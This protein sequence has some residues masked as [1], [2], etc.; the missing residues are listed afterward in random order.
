M[1]FDLF[2]EFHSPPGVTEAAPPGLS[3]CLNSP[4]S[5]ARPPSPEAPPTP[6]RAGPR[7]GSPHR[8]NYF[9]SRG[10]CPTPT[11]TKN[12]P[13]PIRIAATTQDTYPM[14]GRMGAAV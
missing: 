6:P 3:R 9:Q 14:V 12:P 5:G 1:D 10:V 13:P 7:G 4:K 11:P 2:T 8:G